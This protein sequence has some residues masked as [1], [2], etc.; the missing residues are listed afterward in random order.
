MGFG[1]LL[2]GYFFANFMS[3]YSPL[4]IGMLI[5]YPMMI[6]GLYRLAPY[7]NRFRYTF[8]L[9]F[10]S[11]PFAIYF[12]LY[13]LAQMGFGSYPFLGGIFFMVMEWGYFIF[14]FAFHAFLLSAIAALTQELGLA[15]LQGNAWRNMIFVALYYILD[16]FAR[17]PIG[18][19]LA[20]RNY[21]SLS[22]IL[23]RIIFM[24][25]NMY[26]I[27]KCYRHI[28]P[29]GDETMPE[30]KRKVEKGEKK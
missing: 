15:A 8:Y 18:W 2:V 7:H 29:E 28:C 24:M 1:W 26:L 20:H 6:M 25:L 23:L 21:F 10:L 14:S 17:L 3:L 4:S 11:L 5:G 19:V 12:S 27:F 30:P 22:V 16:C 9:S 13:G